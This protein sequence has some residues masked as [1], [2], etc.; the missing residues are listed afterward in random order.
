MCSHPAQP[1]NR[2]GLDPP[3]M[4]ISFVRCA[5]RC[6]LRDN[7]DLNRLVT[8]AVFFKFRFNVKT[9]V[10]ISAL[11]RTTDFDL[12]PND[13]ATHYGRIPVPDRSPLPCPHNS[14]CVN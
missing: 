5:T 7:S 1:H 10:Q 3:L 12:L 13:G 14:G 9:I 2:V 6:R 4:V 8:F 11:D